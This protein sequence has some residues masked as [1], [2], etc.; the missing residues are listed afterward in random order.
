MAD[1]RFTTG[2]ATFPRVLFGAPAAGGRSEGNEDGKE[3][4]LKG[5]RT[6]PST[7]AESTFMVN[8]VSAVAR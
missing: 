5:T 3:S 4:F 6:C 2:K 8:M 7:P 1:G